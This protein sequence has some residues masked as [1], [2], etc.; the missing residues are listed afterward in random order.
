MQN[1]RNHGTPMPSVDDLV[2]RTTDLVPLPAVYLEVRRIIGDPDSSIIDLARSIALDPTLTARL[3]RIVN[4]PVYEQSR[5]VETVSRAVSILGTQQIHDLVLI[6]SVCAAFTRCQPNSPEMHAFWRGSVHRAVLASEVASRIGQRDKE[7]LFVLG[8]LSNLGLLTLW[9]HL[10]ELFARAGDLARQRGEP[11]YRA[12]S[13]LLGF[14][15]AQLGGALLA[16]WKLPPR[17]HQPV[18]AQN[19]V[20][21]AEQRFAVD[22]AWLHIVGRMV[23]A[24]ERSLDPLIWIDDRVWAL[25]EGVTPEIAVEVFGQVNKEVARIHGIFFPDQGPR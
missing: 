3:L 11:L 14:D 25:T 5:P 17:I 20:G 19:Q 24:T 7:R 6:T 18:A 8:L 16:A 15:H 2:T 12:E 21:T 4:S 13:E 22:A 10:P 9:L 1:E 23:E